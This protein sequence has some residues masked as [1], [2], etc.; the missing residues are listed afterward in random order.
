MTFTLAQKPSSGAMSNI[1]LKLQITKQIKW[2]YKMNV[3]M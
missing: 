3:K 1:T 2:K